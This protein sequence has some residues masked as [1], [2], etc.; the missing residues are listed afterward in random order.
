MRSGGRGPYSAEP[1]DTPAQRG[2]ERLSRADIAAADDDE[3]GVDCEDERGDAGARAVAKVS[4][5]VRAFESSNVSVRRFS[6][7]F[8]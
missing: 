4:T 7:G 8:F 2:E 6:Y 5:A 1:P 3:L